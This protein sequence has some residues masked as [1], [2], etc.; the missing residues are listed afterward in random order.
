MASTT[1]LYNWSTLPQWGDPAIST[2][3]FNQST[4]LG[5]PKNPNGIGITTNQ[6]APYS[7][8]F[9]SGYDSQVGRLIAAKRIAALKKTNAVLCHNSYYFPLFITDLTIDFALSGDT[10]QSALTRDMYPHNIVMPTFALDGQCYDQTSYGM[11]TE[12]VHYHQRHAITN[13]NANLMQLYVAGNVYPNINGNSGSTQG[14]KHNNS[15]HPNQGIKGQHDPILC[16]GY[17]MSMPRQHQTGVYAPTYSLNFTVSTMLA[18]PYTDSTAT[19]TQQ[20]TWVDLLTGTNSQEEGNAALLKLNNQALTQ[21][22]KN[23]YGLPQLS[24]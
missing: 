20:S 3:Q 9:I 15:F 18:G 14:V 23:E 2:T 1:P 22:R 24:T 5:N 19:N 7:Q 13:P 21:A 16:L 12:F 4:G 8:D 10:A 6:L 11:L 17:I